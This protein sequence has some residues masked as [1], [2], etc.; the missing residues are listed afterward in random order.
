MLSDALRDR[1]RGRSQGGHLA[2]DDPEEFAALARFELYG[3]AHY[4][5]GVLLT[6]FATSA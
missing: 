5:P 3:V 1:A 6:P 2:V 4:R